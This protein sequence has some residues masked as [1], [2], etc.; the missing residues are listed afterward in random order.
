MDHTFPA[1]HDR[2]IVQRSAIA[3]P[4][5]LCLNKP[6]QSGNRRSRKPATGGYVMMRG[7]AAI[8][9]VTLLA[10][11]AMAQPAQLPPPSFHHLMLNSG[12]PEAAIAFS[13]EAFPSTHR[14]TWG[15]YPAIQ[16][17]PN[18]LILFNK[19]AAP[20]VSDPLAT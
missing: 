2:Q 18:V 7:I 19:V 4:K 1:W 13:T 12:D 14:P 5:R 3:S 17:P 6:G 20:P 10:G 16:S 11:P 8:A 15:G 9:A